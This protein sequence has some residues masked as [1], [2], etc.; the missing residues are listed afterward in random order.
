MYVHMYRGC[1]TRFATLAIYFTH[2]SAIIFDIIVA[3]T[4]MMFIYMYVVM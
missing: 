2:G 1:A 3:V 4:I